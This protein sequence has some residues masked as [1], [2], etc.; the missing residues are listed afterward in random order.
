MNASDMPHRT[1]IVEGSWFFGPL[2]LFNNLHALHHAEPRMPWYR[3]HA[4]YQA[5]RSRLIAEN[6]GL[7]YL[8]YFDVA[9]RFLFKPHDSPQHPTG[10]VPP[11]HAA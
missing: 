3:Y 11:R 5:L 1:A 9:R 8:T 2:F 7:L 6:G 10:R 4:R